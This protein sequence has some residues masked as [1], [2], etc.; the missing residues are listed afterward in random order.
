MDACQTAQLLCLSTSPILFCFAAGSSYLCSLRSPAALTSLLGANKEE[1]C[2]EHGGWNRWEVVPLHE[3]RAYSLRQPTDIK[4]IDRHV[5]F[6]HVFV[7]HYLK[8]K[9]KKSSRA[10]LAHGS[11]L[12]RLTSEMGPDEEVLAQVQRVSGC[13]PPGM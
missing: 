9:K 12:T 5:S 11:R 7:L 3:E 1:P 10:G 2:S 4:C 13:H 8:K 6:C